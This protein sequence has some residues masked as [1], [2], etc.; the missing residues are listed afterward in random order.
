VKTAYRFMLMAV[1][2]VFAFGPSV[3]AQAGARPALVVHPGQSIQAAIDAAR[4][5]D[6][7]VVTQGVY[8]ENL[9]ILT[10]HVTLEGKGAILEPPAVAS[11]R[12]CSTLAG[13]SPNPFGI[14]VA[15]VFDPGTLDVIRPVRGVSVTGFTVRDFEYTGIIV[16]GGR[17]STV[18]GN[19]STGGSGYG[20]LISRSAG[21]RVIGNTVHDATEAGIYIGD[22]PDA[23]AMVAGNTAYDAG[24]FGIFVRDSSAGTITGNN[25]TG[26]CVGIGLLDTGSRVAHWVV[27][28]NHVHGNHRACPPGDEGGS[29]PS[30]VGIFL[31]GASQ[32]IVTSNL[33]L[34]NG[35]AEGVVTPWA[36]GIV[37]AD[38]SLYG[39]GPASGNRISD[40]VV[41]RNR[42]VDLDQDDPGSG[43]TFTHNLCRASTPAGLC[44]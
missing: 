36:G 14:C 29:T 21:S 26:N 18:S 8:R 19:E 13:L 7:V 38:A 43:S 2:L 1:L 25:T 3:P 37:E 11:P 4:P 23:R 41:L 17:D 10:D 31:A 42:L 40:N 6:T 30:G 44:P 5:G 34:D 28:H 20:I 16:V 33:V 12:R 39:G 27:R 32:S 22:S 24:D 9:E 15:G 35:P